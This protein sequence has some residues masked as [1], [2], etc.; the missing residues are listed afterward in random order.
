LYSLIAFL[1]SVKDSED[2][3]NI[4]IDTKHVTQ[5]VL[6]V[7]E[8]FKNDIVTCE[9]EF[10][11]NFSAHRNFH[12]DNCSG[13]FIFMLDPD[14]MPKERLIKNIKQIIID[15][16]ADLIMI[17]RLN[18]CLGATDEWYKAHDFTVNDMDW[19]N[20]PDYMCRVY[21]NDPT[22]RY[23]KSLHEVITG[24]KK[25]VAVEALP[26]LAILHVKAV[27]KDNNRWTDG[28][29]QIRDD[30]NLYDTLI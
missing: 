19:V 9:R 15:S 7:I 13:D 10:D 4:L 25:Q 23:T 1:K 2:E 3:I 26:Q 12:I 28:K 5:K 24:C 6:N 8:H 29:Y 14:E 11:G 16:G 22:I 17:P 18:I 27:E 21:K 30:G 20:W